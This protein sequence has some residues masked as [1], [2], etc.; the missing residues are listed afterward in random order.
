MSRSVMTVW[1]LSCE[2]DCA[3]RDDHLGVVEPVSRDARLSQPW[4]VDQSD[5]KDGAGLGRDY[6]GGDVPD[7]PGGWI[8]RVFI[9]HN[10]YYHS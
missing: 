3:D 7:Q 6:R 10:I 9:L 5:S 8:E 4:L 2:H 1:R